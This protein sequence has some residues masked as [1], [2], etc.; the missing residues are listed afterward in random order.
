MAYQRFELTEQ[1]RQ[2]ILGGVSCASLLEDHGFLL[3]KEKSTRNSL[4]YRKDDTHIIITHQGKGWWN[5][6]ASRGTPE[7]SGDAFTLLRFLEPDLRWFEVCQTLGRYVG[8]EPAGAV[9]VKER[10]PREDLRS[11]AERWAE[12]KP[13]YRNGKVWTYLT[14]ER[15]LPD[16][17]VRRAMTTGCVRD[18]YHAA[19]FAHTDAQ[20]Q[21]CGVELRGPE[22]HICL[23]GS[24]KTLFRFQPGSAR[25]V[26]RLVVC[27]AAIDALSCAAL[28]GRRGLDALYVSTAGGMGPETL[29]ALKS[30]LAALSQ[31]PGAVLEI[32]TDDDEGGDGFADILY[33]LADEAGV[34]VLRRLPP[35]RA[36]D[37]NQTLKNMAAQAA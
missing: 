25:D 35:D 2:T 33:D 32:G 28:D 12:K 26:R 21:V 23:G 37:F 29:A 16:W 20:G 34:A 36:K 30:T 19:W 14:Q 1:D 6:G 17:I 22:T 24:T 10:V 8:V 4:K 7:G 13:L 31:V 9:F 11:P 5:P 27:E 18:G 15:C 3:V